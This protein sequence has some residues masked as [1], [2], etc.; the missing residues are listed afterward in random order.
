M[1]AKRICSIEGCDKPVVARGWC[2]TH[3]SRWQRR[4]DPFAVRITPDICSIEGCN[5]PHNARGWCKM[6][7][8][9]WSK[10]GHPAA[11][12]AF[13]G[14]GARFLHEAISCREDKCLIWPYGKGR[15]GY[16][17]YTI[18]GKTLQTHRIVCR[19]VY[20]EPP[21]P[22]HHAAHRCGNRPC[23]NPRHL[24]WATPVDNAADKLEHGTEIRGEKSNLCKLTAKQVRQ[25]REICANRTETYAAIGE[26][27][28]VSGETVSGI[29]K[30]RTWAWLD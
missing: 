23:V 15:G 20:G 19:A 30:R 16:G 28:G 6:H 12:R 3:Y 11:G 18:G 10:H 4:R 14:E 13:D 9:R 27:F 22:E 21:S 2:R 26:Q 24:R 1:A 25:I 8:S 17:K 7:Y 29:A 5:K